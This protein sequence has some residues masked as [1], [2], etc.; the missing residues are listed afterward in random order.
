LTCNCKEW[1]PTQVDYKSVDWVGN[2][3]ILRN[4]V[5]ETCPQCGDVRLEI[6]DV[7]KA[8]QRY[9]AEKYDLDPRH[10]PM[11]LLLHAKPIM[12]K[13]DYVEQ[14]FR[15][16]K[17]LFYFWKKLCEKDFG[18]SYIHDAFGS[19]R[20]GPVAIHI[21]ELTRSLEEKG[22]VK[23]RWAKRPGESFRWDLTPKGK[24]VAEEIWKST[25]D[26]F[27]ETILKVKENL[28]L[29]DAE[30]LKHKIHREYPAYRRNYTIADMGE[31]LNYEKD[32]QAHGS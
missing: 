13:P 19:A 8:E 29:I 26:D 21:N 11:L 15:F 24:E 4:V 20:A 14:K 12:I 23:V 6:D 16:H 30:Q 22:L 9:I 17:M 3:I 31:H 25:P 32:A 10:L 2:P 27:K 28:F 1:A 7:L 5:A 18:N